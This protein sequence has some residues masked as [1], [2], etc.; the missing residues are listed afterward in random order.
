MASTQLFCA[1]ISA[2]GETVATAQ[3]LAFLQEMLQDQLLAAF[4]EHP[5]RRFFNCTIQFLSAVKAVVI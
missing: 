1:G 5:A 4:G 3:S 2:T